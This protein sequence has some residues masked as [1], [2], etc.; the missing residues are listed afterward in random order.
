MQALLE[1]PL[2]YLALDTAIGMMPFAYTGDGPRASEGYHLYRTWIGAEPTVSYSVGKY[3]RY[4]NSELASFASKLVKDGFD[5]I[6]DHVIADDLTLID[7]VDRIDPTT[8]FFAGVKCTEEVAMQREKHRHDCMLGLVRGQHP[9]VHLGLRPY[10]LIVDTSCISA[11]DAALEVVKFVGS[12][13]PTGLQ[14][15]RKCA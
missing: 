15:I 10:D 3:G 13:K 6:L 7:L 4:L 5:V 8:A 9:T 1:M 12:S 2:F 11:D 14:S